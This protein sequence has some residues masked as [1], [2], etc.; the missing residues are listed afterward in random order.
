MIEDRMPIQSGPN[1]D[2]DLGQAVFIFNMHQETER[3]FSIT[4]DN[5]AYLNSEMRVQKL[6]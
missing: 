2:S 5:R 4:T 1:T 6:G 3:Y